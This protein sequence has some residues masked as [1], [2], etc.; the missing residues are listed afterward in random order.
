MISKLVNHAI[1]QKIGYI[2]KIC[3][4]SYKATH[5][6]KTQNFLFECI[7]KTKR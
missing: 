6:F 5:S 7:T 2:Y 3:Y 1:L 4:F